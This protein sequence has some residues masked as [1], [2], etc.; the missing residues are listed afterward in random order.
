MTILF[1]DQFHD[2]EEK[3]V[4]VARDLRMPQFELEKVGQSIFILHLTE[5]SFLSDQGFLAL[6]YSFDIY[7]AQMARALRVLGLFTG[8]RCP[9]GPQ[10]GGGRLFGTSDGYPN[11]N[12]RNSEKKRAIWIG[13]TLRGFHIKYYFLARTAIFGGQKKQPLFLGSDG[14]DSI[15]SHPEQLW[16]TSIFL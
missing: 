11:K 14:P 2:Q 8:R 15:G 4:N 6:F 10:W 9:H 5:F 7:P 12:G 16:I 13:P 1:S 3:A